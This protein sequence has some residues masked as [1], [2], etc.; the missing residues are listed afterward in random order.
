[1]HLPRWSRGRFSGGLEGEG[2]RSPFAGPWE[3]GNEGDRDASYGPAGG[4]E[5]GRE[6][7][8]EGGGAW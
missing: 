8:R 1:M 4:R 2:Q 3:A 5:E 6:G 7:G